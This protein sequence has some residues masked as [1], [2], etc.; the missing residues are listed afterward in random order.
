MRRAFIILCLLIFSVVNSFSQEKDLSA[1]KGPHLDQKPPGLMPE[2]F[3]P[4]IISTEAT[5]GS[6]SFSN[7][8]RF[9]LFARAGSAQEGIFIM[10]LENGVWNKPRLAPFSAGKHDWD[11]MLAPDGK[12]VFVA[13]ERPIRKG[14]SPLSDHQIWVSVRTN[15]DWSEPRLPPFPVNSAQHDSYPSVT[16]DGTLYFF[17]RRDGGLGNGDIYRAMKTNDQYAEVENLSRPINTIHHE[18]DPYIAS[19]ES[20]IIFC[21]NRPG[22][23]GKEDMYIS[24]K[25]E[26]G[27]WTA[28]LNMGDEVNSPYQEYIP[29]VTPD[30]KY[31]FFTSNKTGDRDIYWMDAGIIERLKTEKLK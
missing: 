16:K 8:G 17:S 26:D 5:E 2:V 29:Y 1:L 4:G 31:F 19:D 7:D 10:E 14:G 13:S 15:E 9:Y 6:S 3:A 21:S 27:S 30:G 23:F 11:F 28:P 22:G 20:Y 25:K 12:T 18:V 24:Y